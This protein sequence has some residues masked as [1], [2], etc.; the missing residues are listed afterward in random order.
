M[1]YDDVGSVWTNRHKAKLNQ[2]HARHLRILRPP[3]PLSGLVAE[4]EPQSETLGLLEDFEESW[5]R[6]LI[7]RSYVVHR[8]VDMLHGSPIA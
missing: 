5:Y 7:G 8:D 6:R 3:G 2:K 4:Q 1:P